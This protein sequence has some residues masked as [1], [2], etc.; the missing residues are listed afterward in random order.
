M[1]I[2]TRLTWSH[3]ILLAAI[4]LSLLLP[5]RTAFSLSYEEERE[6]GRQFFN[7]IKKTNKLITDEDIVDYINALGQKIV[8]AAGPQHFKFR[9]FVIDQ[10]IINA[11][12]A[13]AGYVFV[14]SGLIMAFESEGQLA[15]ILSHEIAHVTS[16][17]ISEKLQRAKMLN[18]A[19]LGAIMAG[20]FIG[21]KAAPALIIGSTA[22][23]MQ[24]ELKYSREDETE[25]DS[26]GLRYLVKAGYAP[27]FMLQAFHILAQNQWQGA[28]DVPDY[29]S[30]HPALHE[31][32]STIEIL[33][34]SHPQ[35]GKIKGRG[36]EQA[37][38][39]FKAKIVARYGDQLRAQNY[40]KGLLKKEQTVGLAH[41]GLALFY[42]KQQKFNLAVDEFKLALKKDPANA[43]FLTDFGALLF[44]QG[45]Y[46]EA[47]DMLGRAIIFKPDY[48]QA[49]FFLA[50]TYQEQGQLDRSKQLFQKLLAKDPDHA[51]GLYNLGLVYGRLNEL[52][53][54]HF[55]TG[56]Y[57]KV[58]DKPRKALYHLEKARKYAATES[59]KLKNRID[60]IIKEIKEEQKKK[61]NKNPSNPPG[62]GRW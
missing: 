40:F 25:A 61:R 41:Y 35:Y 42:Q 18:L 55:N 36:D 31:R 4:S 5:P 22:A 20:I 58:T 43:E 50:R 56:L 32:I 8:K 30:T 57:F 19:T 14:N 38:R 21:G 34:V 52:A 23:S 13:P 39:A 6:L 53:R 2:G 24:A 17:H 10:E 54:A 9:F 45:N 60:Q 27:D 47:A 29:L 15:A 12:A 33:T 16:R 46:R 3:Y 26:K 49:L 51:Q 37:F 7:Y 1:N 48:K 62:P 11:F 44:K 59:P 28:S